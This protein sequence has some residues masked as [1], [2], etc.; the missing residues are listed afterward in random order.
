VARLRNPSPDVGPTGGRE[1]GFD[2]A[3]WLAANGLDGPPGADGGAEAGRPVLPALPP[4]AVLDGLRGWLADC[5]QPC[6]AGGRPASQSDLYDAAMWHVPGLAR[7]SMRDFAFTL[8]HLGYPTCRSGSGEAPPCAV[9]GAGLPPC[10]RRYT[11]PTNGDVGRH[12][13]RWALCHG[14]TLKPDGGQRGGAAVAR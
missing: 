7:T 9:A 11:Y 6:R 14:L 5:C 12:P 13:L 2:A 3:A 1:G 4:A 8:A 10:G